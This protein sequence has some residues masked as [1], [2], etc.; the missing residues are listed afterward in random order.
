V[1]KNDEIRTFMTRNRLYTIVF[2]I[3]ALLGSGCKRRAA[4]WDNH[5]A[6]PLFK[7]DLSLNDIDNSRLVNNAGDS[8]YTL[9]YDELIYS[10]RLAQMRT[11][12]TT[13]NTS[14]TLKK[15]KLTDRS[16]VQS[17]TLGQINPLFRFL[18]G[19]T[20]DVPAQNQ[21][22]LSPVDIDASAFF[23]TATLDSG[24][25]D[26]SLQNELPV[27][28]DL[29]VFQIVNA[30]DQSEVALDSFTN[31]LKNTSVTRSINL[32]NKTVNKALKGVIK[33]LVTKASPGPVL[34]DADKG[35]NVTLTVRSLRPRSAVAAFPN[36][37]VMN[38]NEALSMPMNGAEVKFF[39]V[40]AGNLQLRLETT[41][42]ENMTMF[43]SVPSATYNGVPL[44]RT[45][46]IPGVAP[47]KREVY[48]EIID[49]SGYM[50]DFRG[51]NPDVT[52]TVNTFHQILIVK[53]DSS[54]RKVK[55]TLNDSVRIY[56]SVSELIPEYA[57]GYLGKTLN[58]TGLSTTPFQLFKGLDG[59]LSLQ[60]FTASV[61]VQNYVGATGRLTVKRMEAENIF[62]GRKQLLN[63]TPLGSPID[64]GPPAFQRDAYTEKRITLD[65]NNSN[66]KSFIETLPQLIHYN[67]D[68]E[69]NPNGN[70]SN[71][72][73][74]VFDNSRVD[75]F[76]RLETPANFGIQGI[77]LR[78]TQALDLAELHGDERLK[79][80]ILYVDIDNG[81]PFEVGLELGFMD[82]NFQ[83]L[84]YADVD[85]NQSILP[86]KTDAQG[87]PLSS[88]KTRLTIRV[89]KEKIAMLQNAESVLIKANIKG[90][91]KN[92]KIYNTYKLKINTS[93]EFAYEVQL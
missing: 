76:L 27:D 59:D 74:F 16:I 91:G 17:I 65:A 87:R 51:K 35:V 66:I 71:Y 73:D 48:E 39:K 9:I 84:G 60:N 12:D 21:S 36:Q 61:L 93:G 31:I 77:T 92:K 2:V 13:I 88:T 23:E 11:P 24:F 38:Q 34:V 49:M 64:V 54:G 83:L 89:P 70:T 37:T 6:V 68:V 22:N 30:D 46:K 58:P 25:L 1:V 86:G 42:Q 80:A 72:K 28:V 67:M 45:V 52:D 26:I 41:I 20:A 78:D 33:R 56:Y 5:A 4:R 90:D 69:T 18:D 40:K 14:F 75:V 19:Q 63:A 44:E 62:N 15:L 29:L 57:I 32:R 7:A 43:F 79:S 10:A 55:V 85:G 81:Y 53:L 82:A 3:L 47:G 8:S 50:F